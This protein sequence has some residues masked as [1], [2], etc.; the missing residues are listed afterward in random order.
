LQLVVA[1]SVSAKFGEDKVSV[2]LDRFLLE[3]SIR[4]F[5]VKSNPVELVAFE[6]VCFSLELLEHDFGDF[7]LF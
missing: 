2:E 5:W 4:D 6:L 1:T 7:D 3:G